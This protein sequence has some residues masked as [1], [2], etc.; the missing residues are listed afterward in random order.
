M[1]AFILKTKTEENEIRFSFENNK[2]FLKLCGV[3]SQV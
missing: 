3:K 1:A 2:T